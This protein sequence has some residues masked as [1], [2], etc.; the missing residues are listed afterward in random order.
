MVLVLGGWSILSP[1]HDFL[2]YYD[3][4]WEEDDP[5]SPTE[6]LDDMVHETTTIPPPPPQQEQ[7]PIPPVDDNESSASALPGTTSDSDNDKN[8]NSSL[9]TVEN[10]PPPIQWTTPPEV[11]SNQKRRKRRNPPRRR[12]TPQERGRTP[13]LQTPYLNAT[14]LLQTGYFQEAAEAFARA[15]PDKTTLVCSLARPERLSSKALQV[16][17]TPLEG[18]FYNKVPKAASSTL[19]GINRR[20]AV[21]WG[22]RLYGN[23]SS[24]HQ[25]S[26]SSFV[27]LTPRD[28]RAKEVSCTHREFHVIGAGRFYSNRVDDKSFLWGSLRDPAARAMSRVFF[29]HIS[30]GGFSDDDETI[31]SVLKGSNN[32]QTGCVSKGRGGFQLQYLALT[33]LDDWVAWGKNFP[34]KVQRPDIVQEQVRNVTQQ[35]DFLA[36]TERMDESIVV[37][38]LLLGLNVGDVLST[39]AKVGGAYDYHGKELGCV[40]IQKTHMSPVVREYLESDEWQALNYG[41][42]LLYAAANRSLDLTIDRLGRDR[43]DNALQIY[44]AAMA[45]VSEECA[46]ETIF[47][48]SREGIPQVELA[49]SSCYNADEG[50]GYRCIDRL[51]HDR[52][53]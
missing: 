47:P 53:W 1:F 22:N 21:H 8:H 4:R 40:P 11:S 38:Q 28:E 16:Y 26:N 18:V 44:R 52:G 15:Y 2:R 3:Y 35:Y 48:C 5:I 10:P 49:T 42:Y 14:R 9:Q 45:V 19:A 20:I 46:S 29:F 39:S 41:D 37:L 6:A 32:P 50:C 12:Q 23:V 33:S 13:I 43:F 25:D 27:V 30:Q 7:P 24:T 36:L 34:T 51:V 17:K 31:L